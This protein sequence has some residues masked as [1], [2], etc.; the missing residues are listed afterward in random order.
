MKRFAILASGFAIFFCLSLQA[1]DAAT[2]ERFN[3]LAGQIED[4]RAN[5]EAITKRLEALGQ[6]VENLRS[7]TDK[8]APNYASDEDVKRLADALK[9]V[10]RKRL[11]DYEKIRD[12]LKSLG[13]SLAAPAPP[14]RKTTPASLPDTTSSDK[15]SGSDKV[16]E[17]TVKRGDTLSLIAQAYRDN[18]FK[19][20]TEQILKA[21]PGLKPDKLRVGQKIAIPAPQS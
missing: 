3:K 19:V 4:L 13:K 15:A 10:D 12:E 11:D 18:N 9:E 17:Y 16:F 7:Q 1:Q 14:V 6:A 8:P 21:N 2:E 20:T 5:Q